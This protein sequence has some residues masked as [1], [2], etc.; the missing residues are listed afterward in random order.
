MQPVRNYRIRDSVSC[1]VCVHDDIS[2]SSCYIRSWTT[3]LE[4]ICRRCQPNRISHQHI[5][6]QTQQTFLFSFPLSFDSFV[7]F[8]LYIRNARWKTRS[9][10]SYGI[11]SYT[12]SRQ[13][14]SWS[15]IHVCCVFIIIIIITGIRYL[16]P[17]EL[18]SHGVRAAGQCRESIGI[19]RRLLPI[20]SRRLQH[21]RKEPYRIN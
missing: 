14:A 10:I 20:A 3:C 12:N 7:L 6:W 16:Q 1:L 9:F 17:D 19:T 2:I 5:C 18:D 21:E 8:S 11:R 4:Y 15:D 13:P